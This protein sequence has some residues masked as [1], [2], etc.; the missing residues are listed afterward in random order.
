MA[1]TIIDAL[2]QASKGAR[3]IRAQREGFKDKA[4]QIER[5]D[6]SDDLALR[7]FGLKE[8]TAT[9]EAEE[10]RA[11]RQLT[12]GRFQQVPGLEGA[13]LDTA[14]GKVIQPKSSGFT[15]NQGVLGF[16]GQTLGPAQS[17]GGQPSELPEGAVSIDNV[18]G[19]VFDAQ[20]NVI[21][22]VR[23]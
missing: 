19:D 13:V 3:E 14:T 8:Q 7:Q 20:G 4:R 15:F 16:P 23:V 10:S 12:E 9:R 1:F 17:R 5:Q 11:S 22:K 21:G 6:V 2:Q 18:T